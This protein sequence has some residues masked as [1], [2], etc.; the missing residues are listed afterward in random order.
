MLEILSIFTC[1][2]HSKG[3]YCSLKNSIVCVQHLYTDNKVLYWQSSKLAFSRSSLE[4]KVLYW[5]DLPPAS[6]LR[7]KQ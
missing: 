2:P 6:M 1:M 7:H 5:N 3:L 4:N